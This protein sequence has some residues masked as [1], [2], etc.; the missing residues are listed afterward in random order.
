MSDAI[1]S[2][3]PNIRAVVPN[4]QLK[5]TDGDAEH[6]YARNGWQR[7]GEVPRYALMPDGAWCS[8]TFF[9]KQL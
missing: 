2:N 7:V 9:H 3:V 6:L 4:D 1:R 8:T 5:V